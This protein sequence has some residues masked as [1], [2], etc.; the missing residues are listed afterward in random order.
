MK[1]GENRIVADRG[2]KSGE[3]SQKIEER[4]GCYINPLMVYVQF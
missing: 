4:G 3:E 2:E 1:K